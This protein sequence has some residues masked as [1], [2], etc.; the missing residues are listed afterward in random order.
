MFSVVFL[1]TATLTS[2]KW[3]LTAILTCNPTMMSDV[4]RFVLRLCAVCVLFGKMSVHIFWPFFNWVVYFLMLSCK[5]CLYILDINPLSEILFA[6][7]STNIL[8]MDSVDIFYF[9]VIPFT[10]S[11]V[12]HNLTLPFCK[13][14]C[15]LFFT[16]TDC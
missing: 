5:N 16:L 3:C 12:F 2:V 7:D 8:E 6:N 14:P 13:L 10:H 4:E 11:I 1:M 15:L 9:H